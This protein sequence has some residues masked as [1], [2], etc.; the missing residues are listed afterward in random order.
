MA[1][2]APTTW[3]EVPR[4]VREGLVA[5]FYKK[6]DGMPGLSHMA[7]VLG[8]RAG[9]INATWGGPRPL[10]NLLIGSSLG[11]LGGYGVGRLGEFLLPEKYFK[12]GAARKRLAILGGLLGAAVPAYQ[13]F[14]N[15][16]QTDRFSGILD[17]YPVPVKEAQVN[18]FDPIIDR[19]RFNEAVMRDENTPMRLRAATAGLVE[20]ATAVRGSDL[21]SPFDVAKIAVGAGAGLV[22]GLIAGKTL[23]LL[24]GLTPYG[25]EQVQRAGLW[26]GALKSTIPVALG[27]PR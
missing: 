5:P 14:D 20:A 10:T 25:Q 6:A 24:A 23:G 18:I 17:R 21:V 1:Y 15:I 7:D 4:A 22:S 16:R 27:L 3:E 12:P 8:W 2:V 19:D 11:A 26:A 9:P 13:A